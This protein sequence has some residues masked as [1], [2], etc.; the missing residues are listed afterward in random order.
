MS[1]SDKSK[2]S[3]VPAFLAG[4]LLFSGFSLQAADMIRPGLWQIAHK[5]AVN[6]QALPDMSAMLANIPPA[7]RQQMEA[8]MQQQMA[9]SGA[10]LSGDGKS[11]Q[12]CITPE[13]VASRQFGG[14]P[15]GKCRI[16]DSRQQGN[17]I[18][19]T[20]QCDDPAGQGTSSVT[21]ESETAWR[22]TT[23]M[24]VQ[25]MGKNQTIDSESQGSWLSA[26]CK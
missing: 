1:F 13:Q 8:A 3:L 18:T 26:E 11:I 19:M 7:L 15:D 25:V 10:S 6:N 24:T 22:S 14:D 12:V 20:L 17:T 5:T 2:K 16:T 23:K 9:A 4:V 21:V